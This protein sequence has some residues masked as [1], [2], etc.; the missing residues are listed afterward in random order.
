MCMGLTKSGTDRIVRECGNVTDSIPVLTGASNVF[1]IS[2]MY[3]LI[4]IYIFFYF[5]DGCHRH[6]LN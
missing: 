3:L 6:G 5:S 4:Y 2:V 1:A